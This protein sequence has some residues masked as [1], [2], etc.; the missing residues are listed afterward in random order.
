M[1]DF[2]LVLEEQL[3]KLMRYATALTRDPD[4]AGELVEDTVR[5]ALAQQRHCTG[6]IRTWLLRVLHK[7][8][9]NPFRQDSLFVGLFDR[10]PAAALTLSRLDRAL[11]QLPEEQRAIILLIGLEGMTYAETADILRIPVG[12]MRSRLSRGRA[13]LCQALGV[14]DAPRVPRAA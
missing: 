11:G 3:P 8:R 4:E 10:A 14:A 5:E 2:H 7:L 9:D 6:N 12:T 13:F 1:S